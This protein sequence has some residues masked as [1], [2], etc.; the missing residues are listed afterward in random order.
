MSD[1]AQDGPTEVGISDVLGSTADELRELTR[2]ASDIDEAVGDWILSKE[3][4]RPS[5][6]LLQNV[7]LLRQ[8]LDC[9]EVVVRNLSHQ[10][11]AETK[12]N[13]EDL[14][15]GVYLESVRQV[16]TPPQG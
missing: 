1:A 6:A 16:Y 12:L 8:K 9:F 4:T 10:Q 7:D 15:A 5:V 11:L 3:A 13:S 2:L 14:I